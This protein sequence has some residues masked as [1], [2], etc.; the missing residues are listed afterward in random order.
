M[1][2]ILMDTYVARLSSKSFTIYVNSPGIFAMLQQ[3]KSKTYNKKYRK[4]DE[5]IK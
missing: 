5:D 3:L 1:F 4:N 2:L